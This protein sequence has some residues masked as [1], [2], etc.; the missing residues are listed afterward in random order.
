VAVPIGGRTETGL[1]VSALVATL[2]PGEVLVDVDRERGVMLVHVVD[3]ADPEGIR[4]R[5]EDFY[6]RYQQKVFP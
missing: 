1:A 3:A 5:H 6:R 2:S 4:R